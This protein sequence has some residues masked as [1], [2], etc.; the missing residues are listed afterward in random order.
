MLSKA[1]VASREFGRMSQNAN[2]K[3]FTFRSTILR[4][5]AGA[6]AELFLF[7]SIL[8]RIR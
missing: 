6:R 2:L 5:S 1:S 8:V 4:P 7:C 3:A